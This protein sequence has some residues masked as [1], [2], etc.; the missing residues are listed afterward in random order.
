MANSPIQSR[1]DI[2]KYTYF[3]VR[4]NSNRI[5]SGLPLQEYKIWK[6]ITPIP[7]TRG[8]GILTDANTQEIIPITDQDFI[9]EGFYHNGYTNQNKQPLKFLY[10]EVPLYVVPLESSRTERIILK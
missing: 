9:N 6:F 5:H 8:I 10:S 7:T 2:Q 3:L 4:S 1:N